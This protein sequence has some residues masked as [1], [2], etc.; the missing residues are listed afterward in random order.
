LP[1][2]I[3]GEAVVANMDG[4]DPDSGTCW[5]CGSVWAQAAAGYNFCRLLAW[6]RFLLLRILIAFSLPAQLKS[7]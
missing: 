1:G 4:P 3:G 7:V 6:L 5:E 2:S